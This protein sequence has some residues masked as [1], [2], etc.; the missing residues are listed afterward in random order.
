M[1]DLL[2]P[3]VEWRAPESLPWGGSYRGHEGFREFFANVMAHPAE[4]RPELLEYLDAGE[5]V[6]VRLRLIGRR[7]GGETDFDV[8]E[9]HVFTLRHGKIA[10]LEEYFDTSTVL[11]GLQLQPQA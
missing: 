7:K 3:Q 4:F 6:V 10:S 2:D 8:P 11:R 1:L 9:V 5:R